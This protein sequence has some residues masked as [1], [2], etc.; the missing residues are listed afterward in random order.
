[1]E[2]FEVIRQRH[3]IR[4]FDAKA[5]ESE[6]LQEILGVA[7]GAPSAGN[8]QAYEIYL[9]RQS[10]LLAALADAAGNQEYVAAASLALVFCAH[11][12]R[13]APRY[14]DRGKHLYALQDATLAC[15]FAMLAATALGLGSVWVGA[16]DSDAVA[17]VIKA[18][19][20]QIPVAILPIGYAAEK[21]ELTPRRLL[22][23]LVHEVKD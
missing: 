2:F 13:S 3:C 9:V 4:A 6:K 5:V 17:R 16:F 21:P 23:T 10:R 14:G 11:P 22:E 1:M 20:D 19:K 7:N 15:S 12:A 18:P 8:L